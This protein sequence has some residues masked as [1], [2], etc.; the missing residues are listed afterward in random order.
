M[1]TR[2]WEDI[3]PHLNILEKGRAAAIA[4]KDML[5]KVE[6]CGKI[7][8]TATGITPKFCDG[9]IEVRE[10]R[11]PRTYVI[12]SSSRCPGLFRLPIATELYRS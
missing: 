12:L 5:D 1:A 3:L 9:D 7:A 8:K 6:D 2:A 10:V 4:L 11:R